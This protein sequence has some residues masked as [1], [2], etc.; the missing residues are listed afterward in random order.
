V[1]EEAN[2]IV[3]VHGPETVLLADTA[4]TSDR[5][6][7]ELPRATVAH[8]AM[9]TRT[10]T[11][12]PWSTDLVTAEPDGKLLSRLGRLDH[13]ELASL[14][15]CSTAVSSDSRGRV[16]TGLSRELLQRGVQRVLGALWPIDDLRA[17]EFQRRF[18]RHFAATRKPEEAVRLTIVG[19]VRDGLGPEY[20]GMI[21]LIG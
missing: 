10:W 20:W 15:A 17:I 8:F 14:S 4:A 16:L 13:L 11:E 18:H 3:E 5:V 7:A 1:L 6:L 19:M 12:D 21:Q 2:L 9:H